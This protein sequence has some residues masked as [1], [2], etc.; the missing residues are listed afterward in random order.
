MSQK[1]PLFKS[2]IANL[3]TVIVVL[4]VGFVIGYNVNSAA[5]S[6]GVVFNSDPADVNLD[7]FWNVWDLL[8]NKYPFEENKPRSDDKV[9]GAIRGLTSS[10]NDP[11]TMFLEPKKAKTFNEDVD[12][13]FSGVGMEVGMRDDMIV[14]IAPLKDSPA[15]QAGIKAGD[16]I[17]EID[18]ESASG[19]HV[20]EA[21]QL[22][23][24]KKGTDVVLNIARESE[25]DFLDITI[26]RDTIIVPTLETE[27]VGDNIFKIN[28]YGFSANAARDFNKAINKFVDSDS[29]AMIID[30]RNNPGGYLAMA[31]D[32]ISFFIPQ[33]KVVMIE[34]FG[35]ETEEVDYVSKGFPTL[36]GKDFD[37]VVL[38][39]GGSASASEILAGAL[40]EYNIAT[41][42]GEQ[43]FGKGS[44]Q[45]LIDLPDKS[46]IKITVARWL[47][48][49]GV[50]IEENGLTPDYIV[51]YTVD[52]YE[53]G[54]DPQLEKAIELL[55]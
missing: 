26:T 5:V 37:V 39:D 25:P 49:K 46:S 41:L 23:R 2:V 1:Q 43:T 21:V 53:N 11:H 40:S 54:R 35:G 48:P 22:I 42:V 10:Y 47:T 38:V 13:E 55:K 30:V 9:Y 4:F 33:D 34:D 44:V 12:G 19:M 32:I 27:I 52:D 50:S 20:D 7:T 16:V 31:I 36:A 6:E 18:G 14:V 17:I 8:E 45:E 29:D 3:L 24:G 28:L 15:E 51:E